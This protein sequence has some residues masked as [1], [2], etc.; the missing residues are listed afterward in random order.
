MANDGFEIA[1]VAIVALYETRIARDGGSIE[2]S[3]SEP[4]VHKAHMLDLIEEAIP[5]QHFEGDGTEA[6]GRC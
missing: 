2:R 6:G 1:K 4:T 3:R 5:I